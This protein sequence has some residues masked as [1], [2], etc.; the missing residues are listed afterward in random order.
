VE[1]RHLVQVAAG[2]RGASLQWPAKRPW[3]TVVVP[4]LASTSFQ[5]IGGRLLPAKDG[6]AAQFMY[7]N[8][9]ATA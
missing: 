6:L 2:S 1:V 7:E 5:L 3:F 9:R 8:A 4:D